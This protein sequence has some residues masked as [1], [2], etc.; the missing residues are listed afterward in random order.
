MEIEN[1]RNDIAKYL[2]SAKLDKVFNLLKK[3]SS[4]LKIDG[5][6]VD[7]IQSIYQNNEAQSNQNLISS[8]AYNLNYSKTLKNIQLL[9]NEDQSVQTPETLI[10]PS[11]R[12]RKIVYYFLGSLILVFA[13]ILIS[14]YDVF[15]SGEELPIER[16]L[17]TSLITLANQ[18][19]DSAKKEELIKEILK[20][21]AIRTKVIVKGK[22]GSLLNEYEL[23]RFL[24]K[25]SFGGFENFIVEEDSQERIVIRYK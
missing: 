11:F 23:E 2:S 21:K 9:L 7:R 4:E 5:D 19:Y 22:N 15:L 8:D 14:K 12:R 6:E 17:H 13:M 25:L 24:K 1:I 16:D 10:T 20:S 3:Y 18:N